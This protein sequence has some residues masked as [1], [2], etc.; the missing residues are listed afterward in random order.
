MVGLAYD[1]ANYPADIFS[2]ACIESFEECLWSQFGYSFTQIFEPAVLYEVALLEGVPL[3]TLTRLEYRETAATAKLGGMLDDIA[4]LT[5]VELVNVASALVSISRFDLTRDVIAAISARRTT[6]REDF[7]VGWLEFLVSNRCDG[8][9]GS[10]AAF[11]RMRAAV[12]AR[13]VPAS[14]VLDA[15]TQAVVWY[16]K[17][18][19]L[20]TAEY[21]WWR[22]LGTSLS[23][24][25]TRVE[26]GAL[27]SWYRGL[28]MV[29]AANKDA[30]ATRRYMEKA[31]AEAQV[32]AG[33]ERQAAKLN[34]IKT[35]YESAVKEYL[36][37]RH[38]AGAAEAA[39]QALIDLDPVW[40]VSYGEL[41]EVY[42]K[43]ARV[44]RAAELYEQAAAVGP[45]YVAH[46]LLQAAVCRER[47][48]DLPGALAHFEKLAEFDPRSRRV[49]SGGLALARRLARPSA[50]VFERGLARIETH[51]AD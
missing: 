48:G 9:A 8:G 23:E 1:V 49:M 42:L 31:R 28:A 29:P 34:A 41:A 35:Y 38:D 24:S 12:V 43:S 40:S 51:A 20:S 45:P 27:S 6:P 33:G 2:R 16:I 19:E 18:Q 46:H 17:R 15:C 21:E 36:Y 7:E 5:V 14:R 11:E 13:A 47:C 39:G 26:S 4:V 32:S 44:E 50:A 30:A 10:P 22:S 37:V 3:N 25:S